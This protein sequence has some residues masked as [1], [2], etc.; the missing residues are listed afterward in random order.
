MFNGHLGGWQL[1]CFW[2]IFTPKIWGKFAWSNLTNAHIFQM[3]W[4]KTTTKAN[5]GC[6]LVFFVGRRLDGPNARCWNYGKKGC[7]VDVHFE[8]QCPTVDEWNP[9]LLGCIEPCCKWWDKLS[10][11]SINWCRISFIN[12]FFFFFG[13]SIVVLFSWFLAILSGTLLSV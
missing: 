11:L 12:M 10:N 4:R 13:V 5:F 7:P 1:K 2:N 8:I 9:A 3:G 6:F